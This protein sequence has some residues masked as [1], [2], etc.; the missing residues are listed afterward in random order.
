MTKFHSNHF[1]NNFTFN[2]SFGTQ[3]HHHRFYNQPSA[4]SK[5]IYDTTGH[6]RYQS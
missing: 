6:S 1:F 3:V 2:M 5:Q 4:M